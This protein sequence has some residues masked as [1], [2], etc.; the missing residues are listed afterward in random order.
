MKTNGL[1][2]SLPLELSNEPGPPHP[3]PVVA[4]E[5]TDVDHAR[6]R[7]ADEALSAEPT[8]GKAPHALA[9]IIQRQLPIGTRVT[10]FRRDGQRMSGVLSEI[11]RDHITIEDDRRHVTV[12]LDVIEGWE[13]ATDG[14]GSH[15]TPKRID[16][17]IV[18][19]ASD[20]KAVSTLPSVESQQTP[21]P[22][23]NV[24]G[25]HAGLQ[26]SHLGPHRWEQLYRDAALAHTEERIQDARGLFQRAIDAGG[27]PQV[28]EAFFKMEWGSG[29]RSRARSV[30][31]Q[32]IEKFPDTVDTVR[33]FVLYGHSERKSG[34]YKTAEQVFRAGDRTT[35]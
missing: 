16:E 8:V 1:H 30:I 5:H 27:K 4:E 6:Y 29:A 25:G 35:S 10:F 21:E 7:A 19:E 33:L 15:A 32:A 2:F 18:P 31:R 22:R 24:V 23:Y 26:P 34:Q 20:S 14:N 28:Y 11:G 13:V 12:L 9:S 17:S 3:L